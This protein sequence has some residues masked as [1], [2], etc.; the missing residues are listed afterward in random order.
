MEAREAGE[1]EV[2]SAFGVKL[3]S[4]S[5]S[6]RLRAADASSGQTPKLPVCEERCE[7]QRRQEAGDV[8]SKQLTNTS[9][10]PSISEDLKLTGE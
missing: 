7:K 1:E 6:F 9:S 8:C 10:N 2:K 5:Q 3:R 4:T